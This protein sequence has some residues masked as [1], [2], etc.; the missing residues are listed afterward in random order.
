MHSEGYQV[1]NSSFEVVQR[2]RNAIPISG[3]R[4]LRLELADIQK[5]NHLPRSLTCQ[6]GRMKAAI[7]FYEEHRKLRQIHSMSI[8]KRTKAELAGWLIAGWLPAG[9]WLAGLEGG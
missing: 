1:N 6:L 9:C 4:D 5:Y 8:S 3:N 7:A 2:A